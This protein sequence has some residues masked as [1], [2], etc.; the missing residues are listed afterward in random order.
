MRQKKML[1]KVMA[2]V[3]TAL[4]LFGLISYSS[5]YPTEGSQADVTLSIKLDKEQIKPLDEVTVTISVDSFESTLADDTDPQIN[6]VAA[7]IPV[8]TDVFEFVKFTD[9]QAHFGYDNINNVNKGAAYSTGQNAVKIGGWNVDGYDFEASPILVEFVLKVKGD[10]VLGKEIK[11]VPTDVTFSNVYYSG[12]QDYS[13]SFSSSKVLYAVDAPVL[14]VE[15]ETVKGK[16]DGVVNGLTTAM[17]Y[18]K[19]GET[20]YTKVTDA[21]MTWASGTYYVRYAATGN[22][23]ASDDVKVV[24]G[25][26]KTFKVTVPSNQVGY[27][28]TVDDEELGYGDKATIKYSLLT[29]YAQ[30]ANFAIKVNGTTITLTDGKYV[31]ENVEEDKAV[32]VE[33]VVNVEAPDIMGIINGTTYCESVEFTVSDDSSYTVTVDGISVQAV[34]S[35]YSIK[36]DGKSHIIVAEDVD[37]NKSTVTITVNDGHTWKTPAF[38]WT[39][40]YSSAK[41][42]FV[43]DAD[44]TH[45][46][47][48]DCVVSTETTKEPTITQKGE[49]IYTAKVVLDGKSYTDIK[50][51]E[52]DMLLESE[53]ESGSEI[54]SKDEP[55]SGNEM[56]SKDETESESVAT[57]DCN[58]M[59]MW[60]ALA[61]VS[62]VGIVSIFNF[63]AK[64]KIR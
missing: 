42:E 55:E 23:A 17:E 35:K 50:I 22:Y 34:D 27:T 9:S 43:C 12:D 39:T 46:E 38:E 40:N 3:F 48:K 7:T 5:L 57:G 28:L 64:R 53:P 44:S 52:L 4:L 36:A 18:R 13:Y 60:M 59:I 10:A 54:E 61:M 6:I 8:D 32:T 56:E 19:D 58:N 49:K 41:A 29:G 2:V 15:D 21:D 47:I 16:K 45:K 1:R 24:V 31:L 26:G 14:T 11:F 51:Q 63:K 37:G 20:T 33:G 25:A 62:L 30:T